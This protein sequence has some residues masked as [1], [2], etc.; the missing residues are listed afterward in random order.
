MLQSTSGDP[1]PSNDDKKL[2]KNVNEAGKFLGIDIL[3]HLIIAR[4]GRFYSYL[5]ENEGRK[6]LEKMLAEAQRN[7]K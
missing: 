7:R 5:E 6:E 2:W 3:D 4:D 1:T